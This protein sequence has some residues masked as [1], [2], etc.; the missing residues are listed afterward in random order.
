[1]AEEEHFSKVLAE[2]AGFGENYGEIAAAV[3]E[4]DRKLVFEW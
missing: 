1:V 3:M 4:K 2:L